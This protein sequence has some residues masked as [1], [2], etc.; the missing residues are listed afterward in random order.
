MR[1]IN[2]L[3]LMESLVIFSLKTEKQFEAGKYTISGS[4]MQGR[5]SQHNSTVIGTSISVSQQTKMWYFLV[6]HF[7]T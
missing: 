4:L 6:A 2:I 1:N 5:E 7:Q 3:I